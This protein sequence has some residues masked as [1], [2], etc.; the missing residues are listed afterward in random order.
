MPRGF[1][2]LHQRFR[3]TVASIITYTDAA[4]SRF[5]LNVAVLLAE[6]L[7]LHFRKQQ[8]SVIFLKIRVLFFSVMLGMETMI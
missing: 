3:E 6:Y 8:P 5:F 2:Q 1:M 7:K 4:G